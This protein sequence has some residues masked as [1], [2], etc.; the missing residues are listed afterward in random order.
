MLTTN[1]NLHFE[2]SWFVFWKD[3]HHGPFSAL[4]IFAWSQT[5]PSMADVY[6]WHL[7]QDHW[8]AFAQSELASEFKKN[9]S[10]YQEQVAHH[11]FPIL[12]KDW[13]LSEPSASAAPEKIE[14]VPW[15][16]SGAPIS[17]DDSV[18]INYSLP[19]LATTEDTNP[20]R[21][22]WHL[23]V[24]LVLL[25]VISGVLLIYWVQYQNFILPIPSGVGPAEYQE[26]LAVREHP[27]SQVGPK[28]GISL[29][30]KSFKDPKFYLTSNLPAKTPFDFEIRG[31]P[32]TLVE[33][34]HFAKQITLTSAN[35][36]I[37]VPALSINRGR[38]PA[39]FYR[40]FVTFE[41]KVIAEKRYF[42]GG[43]N[44]DDYR[45]QLKRYH[46]SV[47]MQFAE[48]LEELKQILAALE[49]QTNEMEVGFE[50]YLASLQEQQN[51][52]ATRWKKSRSQWM[53]YQKQIGELINKI[54][55]QSKKNKYFLNRTFLTVAELGK[56]LLKAHQ[57]IDLFVHRAHL[58]SPL[59]MSISLQAVRLKSMVAHTKERLAILESEA[60]AN[61]R[62]P[63]DQF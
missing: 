14:Q 30:Q 45:W 20:Q 19:A 29:D 51:D 9:S 26:L 43:I 59:E 5:L 57:D 38:I 32:E 21:R 48:E 34:F 17:F 7:D 53:S 52:G 60:R 33:S 23:S 2:K 27:K 40:A 46:E 11:D 3:N 13:S 63:W 36:I 10:F 54:N 47:R 41:G 37:E 22:K 49:F 25:A 6:V 16:V 12:W 1:P 28:V 61:G 44:N 24:V 42:L 8:V 18:A 31:I 39:G 50:A 62:I 58:D 55:S 56:D 4:E 15:A 35:G